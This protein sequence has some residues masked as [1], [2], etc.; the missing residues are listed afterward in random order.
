MGK[1][2]RYHGDFMGISWGYHWDIVRDTMGISWRYHQCSFILSSNCFVRMCSP[3][4]VLVFTCARP[5]N[6]Y[7][8][9]INWGQKI[10][11]RLEVEKWKHINYTTRAN[12][13]ILLQI[14]C[15]WANQLNQL[16]SSLKWIGNCHDFDWIFSYISKIVKL[17]RPM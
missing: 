8:K 1:F 7:W 9:H 16:I 6:N 2:W 14:V 11:N 10:R 5:G 4:S 12:L 17:Y 13:V 15:W 3:Y